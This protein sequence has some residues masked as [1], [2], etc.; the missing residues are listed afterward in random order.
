M[1][2]GEDLKKKREIADY[3]SLRARPSCTNA[4]QDFEDAHTA[5]EI[6]NS[7]LQ[8]HKQLLALYLLSK[9]R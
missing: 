5:I 1:T 9:S 6:F 7:A 4:L 2:I 3:T 8:P